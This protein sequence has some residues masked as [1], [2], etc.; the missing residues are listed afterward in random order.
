MASSDK[1]TLKH[2]KPEGARLGWT[3]LETRYPF[4]TPWLTLREDRV[5]IAGHGEITFTYNETTPAVYIVPVTGSGDV[6][7]IRQYRYPVDGWSLEVP[8]G[9]THDFPGEPLE[10]VARAELEE[11]I[12][13]MCD[14]MLPVGVFPMHV[15]KSA[16]QGHVFLALGVAF[17]GA[18]HPASTERITVHAM[19]LADVYRMLHV[20]EIL[21]CQSAM[22]LILCEPA[23]RAR[24]LLR[25]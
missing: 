16:Q 9:G 8:A 25:W 11:E 4:R 21:D 1:K 17:N 3:V 12:G 18:L 15:A 19:P 10:K 20:G 5:H 7:L 23:L 24:G 14:E 13:A 2:D 22:A 6:V